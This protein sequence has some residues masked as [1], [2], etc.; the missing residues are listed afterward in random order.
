[1]AGFRTDGLSSFSERDIGKMDHKFAA[2]S[3]R[4]KIGRRG[5]LMVC[6][7][8]KRK[9]PVGLYEDVRHRDS[10]RP[11]VCG[12]H[13]AGLERREYIL[14]QSVSEIARKSWSRYS[15]EAFEFALHKGFESRRLSWR[16]LQP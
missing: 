1:M 10:G 3:A 14:S 6:W 5:R 13:V 8:R 9:E 11:G 12:A 15:R 4:E 16:R 7:R 2:L